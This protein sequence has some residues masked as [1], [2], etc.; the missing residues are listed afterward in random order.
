[1]HGINRSLTFGWTLSRTFEVMT[2]GP[3]PQSSNPVFRIRNIVRPPNGSER[4]SAGRLVDDAISGNPAGLRVLMRK[5]SA[6]IARERWTTPI[7][8]GLDPADN[9]HI[10][11]GYTYLLQLIAH[12]MAHSSVSLAG[13]ATGAVGLANTRLFPLSL[14]TVYGGGPDVCPHPYEI[15]RAYRDDIGVIPR[16]R[17]RAGQSR[18]MDGTIAGCP[19]RDIARAIPAHVRD[20]GLDPSEQLDLSTINANPW[21]TE[22]L[23][24]DPRNDDHAMISQ[25]AGLW[26][27][28][29]NYILDLIPK[30]LPIAV[31]PQAEQA[32]RRFFVVRFV[33]TLIFRSI[34]VK[35][36]L[37]LILHPDIHRLY[38]GSTSPLLDA[39]HPGEKD[40]VPAEFLAGAFRFGHAMVRD[41]YLVNSEIGIGSEFALRQSSLRRPS[42]LPLNANWL[43]D[44]SRF[45][46]VTDRVPNN[47]HRIGPVY[48]GALTDSQLFPPLTAMDREGLPDRDLV[49]AC[50]SGLWSVPALSAECRAQ[51][52]DTVLPDYASWKDKLRTWLAA[53]PPGGLDFDPLCPAD[54]DILVED[55][56]LPFF[57]LFE[58]G[59]AIGGVNAPTDA[60]AGESL[61]LG[62]LGSII[63]AE[64][65]YGTLARTPI[66]FE[67]AGPH[68]KDQIA[69]AADALL[70][71]GR[72]LAAIPEIATM[73]DLLLFMIGGGAVPAPK[74][75]P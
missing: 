16:T 52:L 45:F 67:D 66:A 19:F 64:T 68:L 4:F 74:P 72:A 44:W 32:Y 57:I 51:G 61:H 53:P 70:G 63:V 36:V 59:Q 1:M 24:A 13:S 39:K 55:P 71:D 7:R 30:A 41:K 26:Q 43:I 65:I 46:T 34:L 73:S 15:D 50:Y 37:P 5:L 29:H 27:T 62:A 69:A 31:L 40:A 3:A 35:D 12:D 8:E 18:R 11:A 22:A 6:R 17:F 49:T 25:L 60:A 2:A 42:D 38:S 9:P 75:N 56:P 28:L 20:S 54:I 58:A 21:R 23:L 10:Q 47:S 48:A 14:E 33:T